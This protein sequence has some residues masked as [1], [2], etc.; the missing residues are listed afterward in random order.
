[1]N[2]DVFSESASKS[3]GKNSGSSW[4][5]SPKPSEYY[6]D[7]EYH[8]PLGPLAEERRTSYISSIA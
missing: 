4:D 7:E 8:K 3:T 5:L 6:S 2:N 1:M